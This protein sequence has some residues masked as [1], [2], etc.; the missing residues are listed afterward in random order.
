MELKPGFCLKCGI[1]ILHEGRPSS[2]F[3]QKGYVLEDGT[4]LFIALC[5]DCLIL[6]NEYGAASRALNL[7][8]PITG[9]AEQKEGELPVEHT[10]ADIAR[11]AQGGKCHF[12][13]KP[14]GEKYAISGGY[15]CCER[16]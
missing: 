7:A 9:V 5:K 10:A 3:K 8:S 1:G 2:N 14:V 4:I 13:K 6:P 11:E 16:C 15:L 12:C